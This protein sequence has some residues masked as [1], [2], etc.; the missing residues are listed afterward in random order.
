MQP[1]VDEPIMTLTV[2]LL[3]LLITKLVESAQKVHISA[4]EFY[5][6]REPG[7]APFRKFGKGHVRTVP[8]NLHIKSEVRTCSKNV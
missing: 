8:G 4:S 1:S 5:G 2:L 7:H 3:V 6:S